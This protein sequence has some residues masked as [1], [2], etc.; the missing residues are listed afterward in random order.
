MADVCV[1]PEQ[2]IGYGSD[3]KTKRIPSRW[4]ANGGEKN[5]DDNNN[6]EKNAIGG[7][8]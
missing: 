4:E 2:E 6:N 1:Q 3:G 5:D 7:R 8:D